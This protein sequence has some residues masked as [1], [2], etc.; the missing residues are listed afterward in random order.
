MWGDC[1]TSWENLHPAPCA[2][3]AWSRSPLTLHRHGNRAGRNRLTPVGLGGF[4]YHTPS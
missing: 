3:P 4:G 1:I 2:L